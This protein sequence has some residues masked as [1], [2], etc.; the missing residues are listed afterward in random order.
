MDEMMIRT[1]FSG[2]RLYANSDWVSKKKN[3]NIC[4]V[5]LDW[6][7]R[8][9]RKIGTGKRGA[10]INGNSLKLKPVGRNPGTPV[11]E[12]PRPFLKS[13]EAKLGA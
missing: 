9:W 1:R 7:V 12:I 5:R 6:A 4:G 2:E 10:S 11:P 8:C 13:H 3:H